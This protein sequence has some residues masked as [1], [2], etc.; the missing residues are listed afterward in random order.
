MNGIQRAILIAGSQEKLAEML[1]VKQQTVS[2][3]VSS[4]K[5]AVPIA[6]AI[7]I[8]Q[9]LDKKVS[10]YELRPDIFGS[11]PDQST[12]DSKSSNDLMPVPSNA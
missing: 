7:E 11:V 6:R 3:W 1:G 9:V 10:R 12:N 8:E 5:G 4:K 2:W